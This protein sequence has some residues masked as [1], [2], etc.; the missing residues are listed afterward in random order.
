M[1][2]GQALLLGLCCT[3]DIKEGKSASQGGAGGIQTHWLWRSAIAEIARR[4]CS[5]FV[6]ML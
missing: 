2:I 1:A 4:V 6:G 3:L 5:K